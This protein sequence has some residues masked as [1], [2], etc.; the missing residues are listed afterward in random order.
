[1]GLISSQQVAA[2]SRRGKPRCL[3]YF[4]LHTDANHL[5]GDRVFPGRIMLGEQ[6][7][8]ARPQIDQT[9][10]A[11]L[12]GALTGEMGYASRGH[13]INAPTGFMDAPCP[14]HFLTIHKKLF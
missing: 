8:A 3:P 12:D 7:Q 11:N 2:F 14:I 4:S 5:T 9:L 1:N 6:A 13:T 10:W